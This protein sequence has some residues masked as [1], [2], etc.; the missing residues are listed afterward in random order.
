MMGQK[1]SRLAAVYQFSS[2]E[3]DMEFNFP[4][5]GFMKIMLFAALAVTD[6][7]A[8]AKSSFRNEHCAPDAGTLS[9]G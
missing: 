4:K 8:M 6:K 2:F 7:A 3:V 1:S 5:R 9:I